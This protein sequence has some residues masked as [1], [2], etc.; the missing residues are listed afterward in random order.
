M[1]IALDPVPVVLGI[2]AYVGELLTR[3]AAHRQADS[4]DVLA[5][6]MARQRQTA[7]QEAKKL[8]RTLHSD[9]KTADKLLKKTADLWKISQE[10]DL[11]DVV[12]RARGEEP[13]PRAYVLMLPK[14]LKP[15]LH[16]IA[17]AAR[18]AGE[19][20]AAVAQLSAAAAELDA[21]ASGEYFAFGFDPWEG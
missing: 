5:K 8:V 2:Y 16:S 13:Q 1:R 12:I 17:D 18:G 19:A 4:A 3:A 14:D 7:D 20:G 6:R 9:V 10:T 11:V 21:K 15:L